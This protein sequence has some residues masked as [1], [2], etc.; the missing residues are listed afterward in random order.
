M[1]PVCLNMD[2]DH[3]RN[4]HIST[5]HRPLL[6][7]PLSCHHQRLRSISFLPEPADGFV[8]TLCRSAFL[9]GSP[10]FG[11]VSG[12]KMKAGFCSFTLLSDWLLSCRRFLS[13]RR[14]CRKRSWFRREEINLWRTDWSLVSLDQCDIIWC[15]VKNDPLSPNWFEN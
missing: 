3:K 1:L 6:W 4:K 14:K 15:A 9:L 10:T 13:L 5:L 8:C 7:E 12:Q 2:D 11:M